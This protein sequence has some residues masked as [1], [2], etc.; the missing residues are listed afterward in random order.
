MTIAHLQTSRWIASSIVST[1]RGS[2]RLWLASLGT[3]LLQRPASDDDLDLLLVLAAHDFER[4]LFP[5]TQCRDEVQHRRRVCHR[6]AFDGYQDVAELDARLVGRRAPEDFRDERASNLG[7][8]ERFRK[9]RRHVLNADAD[10][11]ARDLAV[12]HDL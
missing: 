12:L 9:F 4:R 5:G 8:L 2:R 3:P 6:L 10:P 11:A 1:R 7:Q